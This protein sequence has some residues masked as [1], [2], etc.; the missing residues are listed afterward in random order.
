M[1]G[2]GY[3]PEPTFTEPK[4]TISDLT[5]ICQVERP[6]FAARWLVIETEETVQG[7]SRT[8]SLFY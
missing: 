4:L 3:L 7:S 6:G 8:F 1:N 2:T 5:C